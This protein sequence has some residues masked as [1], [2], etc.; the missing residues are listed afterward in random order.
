MPRKRV[1]KPTPGD[2][3]FYN[4][5]RREEDYRLLEQAKQQ[6]KQYIITPVRIDSKTVVLKKGKTQARR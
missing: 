3:R 1:A 2:A 6:E 4:P 5:E